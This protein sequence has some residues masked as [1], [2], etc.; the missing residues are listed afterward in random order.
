MDNIEKEI[1]IADIVVKKLLDGGMMSEGEKRR[2]RVWLEESEEHKK[3]FRQ[4][5]EGTTYVEFWEIVQ[6]SDQRK[7]WQHLE[8]LTR[9]KRWIGRKRW[10]VYAAGVALLLSLGIW[11]GLH[12]TVVEETVVQMAVIEPGKTQALLVL[13]SGQEIVLQDRDTLVVTASSNI[14]IQMGQVAYTTKKEIQEVEYNTIVVPRGGIYSLI[15]SD[16]TK[17][18]LNSE[19]ELRYP[20]RF[21]EGN[22]E[23]DLRGEAFFEVTSD[24]LRPFIVKTGELQTRVLGTSFNVL[25]YTD[26]PAIQTTL[27]TGRVEVS[28]AN[29][30]LKEILVPGM[31]ASWK[32]GSGDISVKNVNM[33]IQSLWRDG[34]IML[35]DDELESVMRMLSRWYNVTYEW[36]GDRG[37]KH[38]F[39]GKINRNEDLASVLSTLTLLGGPRFEIIG[40]TVYI[41]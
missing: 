25:A 30:M 4:V 33:D 28:V 31:Q 14:S 11:F 10:T 39:T 2:L 26:E 5:A 6:L 32:V 21:I 9:E 40:T 38:T 23:V 15:L 35:D 8:R 20:V 12:R 29:T 37:V 22:R 16:G 36:K 27:F 17:V 24:S 41:Y 3:L 34:V 1:E 13:D 19:S 18:F 7:Q